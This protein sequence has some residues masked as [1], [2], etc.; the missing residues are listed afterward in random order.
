MS[1]SKYIETGDLDQQQLAT[2]ARILDGTAPGIY[3]LRE[4]FGDE[5]WALVQRKK[6]YGQWFRRSV[7]DGA[8][9]RVRWAGR[10]TNRSLTYEVFPAALSNAL[11]GQT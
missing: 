1:T 7:L 9:P 11:S 6:A 4:L 10:R 8:L 3:T 2:V 5:E